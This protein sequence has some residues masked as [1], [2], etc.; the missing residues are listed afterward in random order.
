MKPQRAVPQ[1]HA[2][3]QVPCWRSYA[4]SRQRYARSGRHAYEETGRLTVRSPTHERV[5]APAPVARA[6]HAGRSVVRGPPGGLAAFA[7][8][9]ARTGT[10]LATDADATAAARRAAARRR[11]AARGLPAMQPCTV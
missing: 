8:A 11:P 6:L 2:W 5:S 4:R 3:H 1:H 9:P 10:S 7:R